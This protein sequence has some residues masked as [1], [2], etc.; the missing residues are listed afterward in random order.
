MRQAYAKRSTLPGVTQ[1]QGVWTGGG[2]AADCTKEDEDHS[3]GISALEYNSATGKYL[4]TLT[5]VGQQIVAGRVDV[6]RTTGDEPIEAVI[7]RSTYDRVAKTVEVEFW[8]VTTAAAL[9]DVL[10]TDK[11]C[12]TLEVS[13]FAP[14]T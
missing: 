2:A 13:S 1:I 5:D 4:L 9:V 6:M 14:D 3:D 12:I 7:L 10:T 8:E 11:L